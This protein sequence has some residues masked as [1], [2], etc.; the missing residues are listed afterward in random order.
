M[1]PAIPCDVTHR[2][3]LASTFQL[4]K[5]LLELECKCHGPSGSCAIRTC[6]MT[7]PSV[8]KLGD[9]A[10]KRYHKAKKVLP[11]ELKHKRKQSLKLSRTKRNSK[12]SV[13]KRG[14]IVFIDE[15]PTYCEYDQRLGSLGT[16]GR[17]CNK[18]STDSD[19]CTRLCCGRGY[20]TYE[21]IKTWQCNCTFHW[22]CSVTCNKCQENVDV[23][24][25]K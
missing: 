2:L 15:S 18:T 25:C 22:C 21:Y 12:S 11:V 13:P 14:E 7:L 1:I 8:R 9:M 4:L 20:N 24:T 5:R 19:S 17:Q 10:M 16:V 3:K 23:Y 6:W